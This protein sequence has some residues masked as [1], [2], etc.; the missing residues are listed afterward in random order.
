MIL[1]LYC[2]QISR[3]HEVAN[4]P[5]QDIRIVVAHHRRRFEARKG[6]CK[7]HVS[8][9]IRAR[10]HARKMKVISAGIPFRGYVNL[11]YRCQKNEGIGLQATHTSICLW[12]GMR[13][14]RS[15]ATNHIFKNPNR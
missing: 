7:T 4:Q 1:Y 10:A 11:A 12:Q 13:R 6:V 3:H 9:K 2:Y 8:L 15:L 14:K 5:T